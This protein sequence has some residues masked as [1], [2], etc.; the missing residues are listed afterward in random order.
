MP[1]SHKFKTCNWGNGFATNSAILDSTPYEPEVLFLGT[2]NP[3]TP[4]ANHA[5]FF[6]GRNF[7]WPALKNLFIHNHVVVDHRRMRTIGNPPAILNP[8]LHEIFE[9]CKQLKLSFADLVS[10]VLH[11]GNPNYQLQQNDNVI[12]AGNEYNLIQD[13]QNKEIGGLEQLDIIGQVNWNN[14][15]IIAYLKNHPTIRTVYFT[16]GPRG[17]WLRKWNLI[18]NDPLLSRVQ[19]INIYTPSGRRLKNPQ[20]NNLLFKWTQKF[21]QEWV[22]QYIENL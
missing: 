17:I 15:S 6:Y 20:M 21:N 14:D 10:D 11:V 7:F 4:N 2:F 18:K 16:R 8:T 12:V 9:L 13:G 22:N 1:I 19:F 5:D 3:D